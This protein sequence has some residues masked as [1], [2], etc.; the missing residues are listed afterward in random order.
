MFL[1][2]YLEAR[3]DED[4]FIPTVYSWVAHID[5]FNNDNPKYK[6]LPGKLL[7]RAINGL[8]LARKI[9]AGL[10]TP[11][12]QELATRLAEDQIEYWKAG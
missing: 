3:V 2:K 9:E 7:A 11:D 10:L 6:I 12:D 4:P 8:A 1:E 5:I